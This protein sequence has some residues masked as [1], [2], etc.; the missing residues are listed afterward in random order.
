MIVRIGLVVAVLATFVVMGMPSNGVGTTFQPATAQ[1]APAAAPAATTV[2]PLTFSRSMDSDGR[3]GGVDV[4]FGG[5]N[6]NVWVSFDYRDHDP[7]AKVSYLVRANGEDYKW[8]RINCCPNNSGRAAF[9]ITH[10]NDGG[11]NLPG[12]AY[13]VRLYVN[14]VEVAVGG[15]GIKGRGGLDHDNQGRN[16][17]DNN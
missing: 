10:R 13:E 8:G 15:F 16:G 9:E 6:R 5:G 12:A 2:G 14:D 11:K 1:A 17:N 4:E 7:N 3:P